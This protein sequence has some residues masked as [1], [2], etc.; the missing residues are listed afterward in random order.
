M[1]IRVEGLEEEGFDF[2]AV[3]GGDTLDLLGGFGGV[4]VGEVG[5]IKVAPFVGGSLGVAGF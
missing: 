4:V 5:K 3:G 1:E 2:E